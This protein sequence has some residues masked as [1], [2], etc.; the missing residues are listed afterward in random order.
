MRLALSQFGAALADVSSNV[1]QMRDALAVASDGGAAV[2]CFP[3]LCVSGYL[4]RAPE[5]SEELLQD[6]RDAVE[7]LARDS[8]RLGLT[9]VYGTPWRHADGGLRNSVVLQ[10]P[11]GRRVVYDKTHLVE[12][13]R[14]VFLAGTA[15]AAASGGIGL[16]CCYDLGF[17][18]AMRTVTLLGARV[19]VVPMAWEVPG[20]FVMRH[21]VAA[22]AVENIAYVVAINQCGEVGE[23]Q[24]SGGSCVIDP[25]GASVAAIAGEPGVLIADIDLGWADRLRDGSESGTYRL[26]RD[27]R[28]EIY[29]LVGRQIDSGERP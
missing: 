7:D 3:E 19:L 9:V 26:L 16:A 18:E 23:L 13:E 14:E 12:K 2:I 1:C 15:F 27:R 8:R 11:S 28:P 25:L 24:F 29:G 4:L 5:Y 20:S 10:E 22:R 6:A 17:P 21:L